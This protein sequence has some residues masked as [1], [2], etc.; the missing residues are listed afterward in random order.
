MFWVPKKN[1]LIEKVLLSTH[2]MFWLI[3]KFGYAL[4]SRGLL[5]CGSQ[6][7]YHGMD[8][9]NGQYSKEFGVGVCVHQ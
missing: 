8:R 1:R 4:L 7:F 3:K 2:N 6:M 9:V 5:C